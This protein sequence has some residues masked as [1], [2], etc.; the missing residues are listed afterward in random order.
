MTKK[1]SVVEAK[2][3][4]SELTSRVA[5]QKERYIIE[6]RGKAVAALVNVE[7]LR[8]IEALPEKNW[9]RGLLAAVGAWEDYPRLDKFVADL[10]SARRK[11]KDRRV[12]RLR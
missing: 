7:E 10:Y 6:R 1:V 12:Q 8:R 11:S 3:D 4:F 9:K 5:L 2:R